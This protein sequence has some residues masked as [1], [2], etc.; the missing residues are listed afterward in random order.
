M[1]VLTHVPTPAA[2]QYRVVTINGQFRNVLEP[3]YTTSLRAAH[4][5]AFSRAVRHP[6]HRTCL[7]SNRNPGT[8]LFDSASA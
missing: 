4:T 7:I 3:V 8:V 6:Q 2:R 5:E 1:N